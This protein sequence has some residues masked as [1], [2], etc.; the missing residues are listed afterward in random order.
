MKI[1]DRIKGDSP[2]FFK[3]LTNF[4]LILGAVGTAIMFAPVSLPV[5]L[6]TLGGYLATVGAVGAGVSKLTNKKEAET[7]E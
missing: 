5:G 4:C 7:N 2:K 3:K 1:K 6:V